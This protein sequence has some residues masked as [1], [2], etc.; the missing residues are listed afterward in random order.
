MIFVPEALPAHR[1]FTDIQLNLTYRGEAFEWWRLLVRTQSPVRAH[2]SCSA[3]TSL[4]YYLIV[5]DA[6][7][8]WI[9][10]YVYTSTTYVVACPSD[11]RMQMCMG[12][13]AFGEPRGEILLLSGEREIEVAGYGALHFR[14]DDEKGPCP[15]GIAVLGRCPIRW[16]WNACIRKEW[17][18]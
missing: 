16:A 8:Q 5:D 12:I 14:V 1:T 4:P 11:R 17:Y 2:V 18:G 6:A 3:M 10:D 9:A 15:V 7:W 13:M